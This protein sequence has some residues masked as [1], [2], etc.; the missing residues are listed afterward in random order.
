MWVACHALSESLEP[1]QIIPIVVVITVMEQIIV[2]VVIVVA[3]VIW[4]WLA[5]RQYY[6]NWS[7]RLL[8]I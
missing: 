8:P 7:D 1:K 6:G 3:S 5:G 2:L 4:G